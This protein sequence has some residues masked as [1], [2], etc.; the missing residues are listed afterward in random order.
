MHTVKW[1]PTILLMFMPLLGGVAHA[2][3]EILRLTGK[4]QFKGSRVQHVDTTGRSRR[5]RECCTI[6]DTN[7][8]AYSYNVRREVEEVE[9]DGEKVKIYHYYF[10]YYAGKEGKLGLIS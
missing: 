7:G 6:V 5:S 9:R 4:N 10:E 3:T 1:N 2:D 8:R